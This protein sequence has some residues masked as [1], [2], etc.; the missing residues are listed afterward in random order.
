MLSLFNIWT[1]ARFEIKTLLRSWFFRI[2]CAVVLIG[3]AFLNV[4]LFTAANKETPWSF[5][6]IPA[7]IS[8]FNLLILN[9]A[10]AVMAVFLAADFLKRDKADTTEVIY[11]RSMTN[12]DYVLGKVTGLLIVFGGL[13]ALVLLI[14][15]VIQIAFSDVPFALAPHLS[16]FV[17]ISL[18][19]LIFIFGL[20]LITMT[21]LRHQAVTFILLLG[22]LAVSLVV[23][24]EKY[25]ASFDALSFFLPLAF[26]DF[27][28]FSQPS[29]IW[30]QRAAFFFLGTGFIFVS[31][32][33]FRRLPQSRAMQVAAAVIAVL[34]FI[35]SPLCLTLY[36][37]QAAAGPKQREEARRLN[38]QYAGEPI[39]TVKAYDLDLAHKG[40][41]IEVQAELQIANQTAGSIGKMIFNLNPGLKINRVRYQN[42]DVP[43]QRRLHLLLVEPTRPLSPGEEGTLEISYSG[44]VDEAITFLQTPESERAELNSMMVYKMDKRTAFI[45]PSYVLLTPE[46]GWYPQSGV[47]EGK[48]LLVRRRKNFSQFSLRVQ[49]APQLTVISQGR[50]EKS[51]NVTVFRPQMPMPQISLVIGPYH[52]R[53][54]TVDSVTFHLYTHPRHEFFLP[55]VSQI[56]DTLPA[57]IRD[58]KNGYEKRLGIDYPYRDFS[59][60]E[61][62]VHFTSYTS[63]LRGTDEFIQPM[64]VMLPENAFSIM[65]ADFRA[66]MFR[67]TNRF[68]D[69]N[70]TLSEK[71]QQ[72]MM[73]QRFF[74]NTF[75]Y[76]FTGRFFGP[77]SVSRLYSVFSNFYSFVNYMAEDDFPLLDAATETFMRNKVEVAG[78]GFMR[79]RSGLTDEEKANLALRDQSLEQILQQPK[80]VTLAQNAFKT[81][82]MA[83]FYRLQ[84][85]IGK[86]KLDAFLRSG[87][88]EHRLR[89]WPNREWEAGLQAFGVD[90]SRLYQEWLQ[91]NKTPGYTFHDVQNYSLVQ[92]DRTR[93]Q[94]KFTAANPTQVD[95]VILVDFQVRGMGGPGGFGGFGGFG[96]MPFGQSTT[97]YQTF[98]K[99]AAG[100]A[101][102]LAFITDEEP[103]AMTISTS[104][105]RNLPMQI[106]YRFDRFEENQKAAPEV[107][108]KI[109]PQIPSGT[110]DTEWIVD[111]EDS[112]FHILTPRKTIPLQKLFRIRTEEEEEYQPMRPWQI[113]DYW[114]KTINSDFY[115]EM[116]LSAHFV[117]AGDGSQKVEWV[118]DLPEAGNYTVYAHVAP[119]RMRGPMGRG[120]DFVQ[121]HHFIVRHDDGAEQV[122]IDAQSAQGWTSL[123]SYYFSAGPAK[124]ELTNQSKGRIVIA[125][126][127]KWAKR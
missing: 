119:I 52:E 3:L 12:G 28:G 101:K 14:S 30:L 59:I 16:Y 90:F 100:Q 13:N 37:R 118:A 121:D 50:G 114:T 81:K 15:A 41:Q 2:F 122:Q 126:A 56:S 104:V 110:S 29:L 84:A 77:V 73:I 54:V 38:E 106:V 71:E 49:T 82:S 108:E 70:Q 127:V 67:M 62:P 76:P 98:V 89:A 34:S 22:L 44:A 64:I 48:S 23:L 80:D 88:I 10:Q 21:V 95:G 63:P 45:T 46:C 113:P 11:M 17:M 96:F 99:I 9:I 1:I 116:V 69:R 87:L 115:G 123:G 31:I 26:S 39:V 112:G 60:V 36:Y 6:A 117:K 79:F 111:N 65:S 83:L 124:V 61:A 93:Y 125:D 68:M 55:F 8:Y 105:S 74:E 94:V 120:Q 47:T 42:Q 75:L 27:V 5:R 66:N 51:G 53:S 35:L 91:Q 57:M 7:S 20:A 33:L 24:R 78:G 97:D 107:G 85:E 103:R 43:F 19:T 58:L 109:L 40:E 32:L 4:I 92:G 86:E 25:A 18:P 72:Y 102:Q